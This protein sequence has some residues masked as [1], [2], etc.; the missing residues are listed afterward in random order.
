MAERWIIMAGHPL[1]GYTFYGVFPGQDEA[2][3][4]A[5]GQLLT[6]VGGTSFAVELEA[7]DHLQE[8]P[9]VAGARAALD[10]YDASE[11]DA[12][13]LALALAGLL[14]AV[15]GKAVG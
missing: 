11:P 9:A 14:E 2:E 15:A 3:E 8:H 13:A 5:A 10:G 12:E 1:D 6:G 4:W 7:D